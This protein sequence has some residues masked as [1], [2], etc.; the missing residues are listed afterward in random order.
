MEIR[1]Q[2]SFVAALLL[3]LSASTRAESQSAHVHGLATLTIALEGGVLEMQF[4]SPAANLLGFEHEAESAEQ[5]QLVLQAEAT[6]KAPSSLFSFSGASCQLLETE[7]D[8]SDVLKQDHHSHGKSHSDHHHS[9]DHN[10][11]DEHGGHS[12]IAGHYRYSCEPTGAEV[13]ISVELFDSFSGIEKIDAM[14]I[15]E[16]GQSAAPLTAANNTIFLK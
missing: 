2:L 11:S 5:K 3:I 12:D 9:H 10:H 8:V 16:S 14:W 15:T 7:V 1:E 4:K 6:L 13:S